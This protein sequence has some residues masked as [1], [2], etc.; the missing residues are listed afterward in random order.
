MA[1][2]KV[3]WA[4][5]GWLTLLV[6]MLVIPILGVAVDQASALGAF[7]VPLFFGTLLGAS[8]LLAALYVKSFPWWWSIALAVWALMLIL[9]HRQLGLLLV[10]GVLGCVLAV[11]RAPLLQAGQRLVRWYLNRRN[12]ETSD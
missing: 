12:S 8:T 7:L 11:F 6:L 9:F 5:W 2:K 10:G 4:A 3:T 1:E